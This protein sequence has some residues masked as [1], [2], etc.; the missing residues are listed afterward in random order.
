LP[1]STWNRGE[2]EDDRRRPICSEADP[3][4][5]MN[6]IWEREER[7]KIDCFVAFWLFLQVTA[8][9]ERKGRRGWARSHRFQFIPRGSAWRRRAASVFVGPEAFPAVSWIFRGYYVI[10]IFYVECVM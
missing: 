5:R 4:N 2:E 10:I 7:T 1:C 6:Q 8:G 3:K 9:E